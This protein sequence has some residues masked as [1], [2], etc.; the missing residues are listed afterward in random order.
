MRWS[1][2]QRFRTLGGNN[3]ESTKA[4]QFKRTTDVR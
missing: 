3:Y 2:R 1:S 4:I